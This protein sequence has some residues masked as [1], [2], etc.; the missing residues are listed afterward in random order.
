MCNRRRSVSA[1]RALA[2]PLATAALALL[3]AAPT[4]AAPPT[5][6]DRE[7]LTA[8]DIGRAMPTAF[9]STLRV[10]PL[11]GPGAQ[12]FEVWRDAT[13]ALVRFLDPKQKGKAFLQRPEGTWLLTRGARPVRLGTA[14]RVVAGLSLQELVGLAY[15]RDFTIENVARQGA[16]ATTIVSFTLRAK[17]ADLPYPLATYVVR[18]ATRRPVRVEYRLANGRLV[19]MVEMV[20]WRP[21]AKLVPAETIAKDL[22]GGRTP[23]RVRLLAVEERKPPAHLFELTPAGDAAR[24]ALPSPTS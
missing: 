7:L 20:A 14:S 11:A 4:L 9:R 1:A 17:A 5:A 22:V 24:A 21:G 6:A 16:G 23:L 15:S 19:R 10:E 2:V 13:L 3:L 18:E 12:S 8:A